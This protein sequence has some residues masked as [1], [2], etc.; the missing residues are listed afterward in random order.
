MTSQAW[1]IVQ[2]RGTRQKA[3]IL[4]KGILKIILKLGKQVQ[5]Q[6]T[7]ASKGLTLE[8]SSETW[9][10]TCEHLWC[11]IKKILDILSSAILSNISVFNKII[12]I[13]CVSLTAHKRSINIK[14]RI[15]DFLFQSKQWPCLL[16]WACDAGYINIRMKIILYDRAGCSYCLFS[17]YC[18]I[19]IRQHMCE[20]REN[21]FPQ[22]ECVMFCSFM[23]YVFISFFQ[24]SLSESNKNE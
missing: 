1:H 3:T 11:L 13:W 22:L 10:V 17:E 5:I 2:Y 8:T 7:Q 15:N 24:C 9:D 4:T 19:T 21:I 16:R 18:Q 20:P 12:I 23:R 14:I 6:H